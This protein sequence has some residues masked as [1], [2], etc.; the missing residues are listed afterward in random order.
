MCYKDLIFFMM[1]IM[2]KT[3]TQI[4][5]ETIEPNTSQTHSKKKQK[6]QKKQE[7]LKK[8]GVRCDPRKLVHVKG[9]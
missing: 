7:K 9:G 1:N 8:K 6:K 4:T 3:I 5:L 2:T